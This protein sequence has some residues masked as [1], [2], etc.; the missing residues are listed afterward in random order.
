MGFMHEP[1]PEM[2][3]FSVETRRES[4]YLKHPD[5]II[6]YVDL[7][8]DAK[9]IDAALAIAR[10]IF[11]AE[12]KNDLPGVIAALKSEF[13]ARV[14][15]VTSYDHFKGMVEIPYEDIPQIRAAFDQA[16]KG[17]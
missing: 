11:D 3:L 1:T 15:A 2:G 5:G 16:E 7:N 17:R 8:H 14:R 4:F 12:L 6:A 10:R 13:A 9:K